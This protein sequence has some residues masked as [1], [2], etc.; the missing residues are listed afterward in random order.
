MTHYPLPVSIGHLREASE[1]AG[2]PV[3]SVDDDVVAA[4]GKDRGSLCDYTPATPV[5]ARV[6]AFDEGHELG[7]RFLDSRL[8]LEVMGDI[9]RSIP[10]EAAIEVASV[11]LAAR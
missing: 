1:P 7:V 11:L 9:F 6:E 5:S 8:G 4:I 2:R 10:V 3:A